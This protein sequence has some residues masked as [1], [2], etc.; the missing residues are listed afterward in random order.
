MFEAGGIF[1]SATPQLEHT[2]Q[3][4]N[5]TD[6]VVKV[7]GETHSCVC[8]QVDLVPTE[9]RPGESIPLHLTIQVARGLSQP[10]IQCYVKTDHPL[11]PEWV[12]SVSYQTYPDLRIEPSVILLTDSR[13]GDGKTAASSDREPRAW[14][15][16]YE[17]ADAARNASPVLRSQPAGLAIRLSELPERT[18]LTGGVRRSRYPIHVSLRDDVPADGNFMRSFSIAY[19]ETGLATATVSW[20][21]VGALSASPSP[22]HFG[23]VAP[24][25]QPIRRSVLIQ[26][27]SKSLFRLKGV[28]SDSALVEVDDKAPDLDFQESALQHR[29]A[30]VF[31]PSNELGR[32][33]SG[34]VRF[35]TDLPGDPP[36]SVEWSVFLDRQDGSSRQPI[37]LA[38]PEKKE[39]R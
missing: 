36:C 6:R 38:P 24:G 33:T 2:F 5:T 10:T 18:E 39:K 22:L 8:T 17:P 19:G 29:V 37:P 23:F 25:S 30:L 7:L 14:L 35:H 3:V 21:K 34:R 26:S 28:D 27:T 9:L 31:T 15:E 32:M 16:V 4:R 1:A 20:R 13:T 11:D 12:Y